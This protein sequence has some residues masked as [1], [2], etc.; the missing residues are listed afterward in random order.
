AE[1]EACGPEWAHLSQVP[2]WGVVLG[3]ISAVSELALDK[4]G[5]KKQR[6]RQLEWTRDKVGKTLKWQRKRKEL[7][8]ALKKAAEEAAREWAGIPPPYTQH[9]VGEMSFKTLQD[10]SG[11]DGGQGVFETS[12]AT[13]RGQRTTGPLGMLLASSQHWPMATDDDSCIQVEDFGFFFP[14][15][16]VQYQ[17]GLAVCK[18][19]EPAAW[20]FKRSGKWAIASAS[21]PESAPSALGVIF[22]HTKKPHKHLEK[23]NLAKKEQIPYFGQVQVVTLGGLSQATCP[24][25]C[26]V[27]SCELSQWLHSSATQA[28]GIHELLQGSGW[29][30]KY[31]HKPSSLGLQGTASHTTGSNNATCGR[32][33]C[34]HSLSVYILLCDHAC[35]V[36]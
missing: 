31:G 12:L 19:D 26:V 28:V 27:V 23:N 13:P 18:D 15:L 9:G 10:C 24:R 6:F 22:S 34:Q 7:P 29:L 2:D 36:L 30:V 35:S 1:E 3:G 16:A 17:P 5:Q 4:K 20:A 11:M 33:L 25:G 21:H 32:V 14:A 8:K